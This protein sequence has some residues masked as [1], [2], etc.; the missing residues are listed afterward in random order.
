MAISSN[1]TGKK[2]NISNV[3]LDTE[4]SS[5]EQKV[6]DYL[7]DVLIQF[8]AP[9]SVRVVKVVAY[10]S[11]KDTFYLTLTSTNTFGGSLTDLYELREREIYDSSISED[12][13]SK[14]PTIFGVSYSFDVSKLNNAIKNY[15][16]EQGWN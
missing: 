12:M 13:F 5:K 2:E 9:A 14:A 4:L 15:C 1:G 7:K 6:F 8:D 11:D 3:S 16:E 10:N